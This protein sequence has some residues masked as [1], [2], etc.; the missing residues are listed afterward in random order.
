MRLNELRKR[1]DELERLHQLDDDVEVLFQDR[2]GDVFDVFPVMNDP[3]EDF[4]VEWNIPDRWICLGS[5]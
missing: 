4:P 3:D 2:K 1:L 5:S